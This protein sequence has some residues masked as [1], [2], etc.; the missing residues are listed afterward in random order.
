MCLRINETLDCSD[1]VFLFD[2]LSVDFERF[3]TVIFLRATEYFDFIVV[4]RIENFRMSMRIGKEL[5]VAFLL[6]AF[7]KFEREGEMELP[8]LKHL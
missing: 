5:R 1:E 8:F 2:Y 7:L 6:N 4:N 3:K